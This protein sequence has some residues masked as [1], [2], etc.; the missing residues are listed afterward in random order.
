MFTGD[1]P[2]VFLK[3]HHQNH[4][5]FSASVHTSHSVTLLYN[6][7]TWIFQKWEGHIRC[8]SLTCCSTFIY[9][10]FI[11]EKLFIEEK[12]AFNAFYVW[13]GHP[14]SSMNAQY[15]KMRTPGLKCFLLLWF[16]ALELWC[17][18]FWHNRN[19][20]QVGKYSFEMNPIFIP[21]LIGVSLERNYV[22]L[23]KHEGISFQCF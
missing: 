14:Q 6:I 7:Y 23:H 2:R 22:T 4:S 17:G 16:A 15:A 18:K 19:R 1:L 10:F 3:L 20:I 8:I 5:F 11:A 12:R 21:W 9:L 13:G